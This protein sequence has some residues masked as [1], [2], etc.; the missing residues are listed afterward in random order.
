MK[1]DEV[2]KIPFIFSILLIDLFINWNFFALLQTN[3]TFTNAD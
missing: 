1:G 3:E 2:V